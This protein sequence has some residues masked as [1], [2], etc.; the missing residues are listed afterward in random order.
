MRKYYFFSIAF[1]LLVH[2]AVAQKQTKQLAELGLKGMVKF[3]AERSYV[4]LDNFGKPVKGER[5]N[6]NADYTFNKTGSPAEQNIYNQNGSLRVRYT[7]RYNASDK[8]TEQNLYNPGGALKSK[9]KY[10]YNNGNLVEQS[11]FKP[12][13]GLI[14]KYTYEYDSRSYQ[15]VYNWYNSDGVLDEKTIYLYD[16]KGNQVA[17]RSVNAGDTALI[18]AVYQYDNKGNMTEEKLYKANDSLDKKTIFSYDAKGNQTEIKEYDSAFTKII[19][20]KY[21]AQNNIVEEIWLDK[22]GDQLEQYTYKYDYDKHLNWTKKITYRNG[23]PVTIMEREF[24]YF[25]K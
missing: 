22:N 21:N 11:L 19:N 7:Y 10:R 2:C 8:L 17:W 13:G 20:Y 14:S 25:K 9:F 3:M 18:Q 4:A 15:T 5:A 16:V 23:A 24:E 12:G 1:I 6:D